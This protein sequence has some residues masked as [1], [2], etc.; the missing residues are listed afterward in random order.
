MIGP[1]GIGCD[2]KGPKPHLYLQ[3][4]IWFCAPTRE[5]RNS[6]LVGSGDT[7]RDAYIHHLRLTRYRAVARI[8]HDE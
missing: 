8:Y 7:M 5:R 1:G 4:G 3:Y 2:W 6:A